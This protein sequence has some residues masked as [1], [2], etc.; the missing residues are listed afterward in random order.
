MRSA[1]RLQTVRNDEGALGKIDIHVVFPHREAD[2]NDAIMMPKTRR[3]QKFQRY[4]ALKQRA[5]RTRI[6]FQNVVSLP[7]FST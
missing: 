7:L 4:P 2:T 3:R 5:E 6:F 1:V